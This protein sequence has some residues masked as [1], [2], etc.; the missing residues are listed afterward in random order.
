VTAERSIPP[1]VH[2]VH[3]Q[4]RGDELGFFRGLVTGL[5]LCV[6]FWAAVTGLI[7]GW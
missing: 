7:A 2:R 4:A 3:T 6:P 5:L 1:P